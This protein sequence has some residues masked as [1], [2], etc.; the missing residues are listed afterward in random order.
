MPFKKLCSCPHH[1]EWG[2]GDA[3]IKELFQTTY[4]EEKFC[5]I[6]RFSISG[7]KERKRKI[8]SFCRDRITLQRRCETLEV[9]CT[10]LLEIRTYLQI[11]TMLEVSPACER[12]VFSEY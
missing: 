5:A 4:A 3:S 8:C 6:G 12:P 10:E 2:H 1:T 9:S 7:H 11:L